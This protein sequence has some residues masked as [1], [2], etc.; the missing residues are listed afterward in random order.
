MSYLISQYLV[1]EE[2]ETLIENLNV[3]HSVS[4]TIK[5]MREAFFDLNLAGEALSD[6]E[7][8]LMLDQDLYL[9]LVFLEL[10]AKLSIA[11]D[12]NAEGQLLISQ[13]K[14]LL[15]QDMPSEYKIIP[16]TCEISLLL[17]DGN[18]QLAENLIEECLQIVSP[19]SERYKYLILDYGFLL[20]L[21]CRMKKIK[22]AIVEISQNSGNYS[23][24]SF[25]SIVLF[26]DSTYR[27]ELETSLKLETEIDFFTDY[28]HY[29]KKVIKRSFL[30]NFVLKFNFG[31]IDDS[32][33]L[34]KI[35]SE[36]Q[37][38]VK[39]FYYLIKRIP[40]EAQ[41]LISSDEIEKAGYL[42]NHEMEVFRPICA[43]L[44]CGNF[45]EA[46]LLLIEKIQF[47]NSHYFDDFIFARIEY[48]EGNTEKALAHFKLVYDNC[49]MNDCLGRLEFEMDLACELKNR[50]NQIFWDF[51]KKSSAISSVVIPENSSTQEEHYDM[52]GESAEIKSVYESIKKYGPIDLPVLI[53]GETGTG[54]ELTAR[55]LHNES[56]RRNKPYL[57]INCGAISESLLHSEL[58]GYEQGAF[59][60]ASKHKVGILEAAGD[61]T[62]F[63]DEI[64]EIS[65]A[66]QVALLRV[67][68]NNEIRP[69]G[70][71]KTKKLNF[72]FIAATN[73]PLQLLVEQNKFRMDLLYRLQR[74]QITLPPLRQRKSD[75]KSLANYFLQKEKKNHNF[76]LSENFIKAI[77]NYPWPGNIRELKNEM[78]KIAI[79]NVNK[80]HFTEKDLPQGKFQSIIS[81]GLNF[82]E[83]QGDF[84]SEESALEHPLNY[85]NDQ[86]GSEL[87]V[88]RSYRSDEEEVQNFLGNRN[89]FLRRKTKLIKLFEK[90]QNLS[91]SE[92]A[93]IMN[94]ALNTAAKDLANLENEKIIERIK[95]SASPRTHYFSLVK[96]NTKPL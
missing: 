28:Y 96:I 76:D 43:A 95:P 40:I 18:F 87:E 45:Q 86:Q 71:T 77:E 48:A 36:D 5:G 33:F 34:K 68:E 51:A 46:K 83:S 66:I 24:Q 11:L 69:V 92:V 47:E 70:G 23:L 90:Y 84:G 79:L 74:F 42:K 17:K 14:N 25:S 32:E 65:P 56:N 39:I 15:E 27:C 41:A 3:S 37:S 2:F 12:R 13:M 52:L 78:E 63:L 75:I 49:L 19:S 8:V 31:K 80:K 55:A 4:K 85:S 94:L 54:K 44:S 73:A 10:R 60:G 59:T 57:A 7:S 82:V 30:F 62:V 72:R 35:E 67:L 1:L 64:G 89:S 6:A 50:D 81:G 93:R 9:Q 16:I 26:L 61:G 29:F 22:D 91:R 21:E 88:A 58:F 53:I 20:A 38:D